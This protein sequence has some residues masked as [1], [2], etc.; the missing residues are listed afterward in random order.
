MGICYILM[1]HASVFT[2]TYTF[3]IHVVE[4]DLL[5]LTCFEIF[6]PRRDDENVC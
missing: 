2:S 3:D 1:L 5:F 6:F 4:G